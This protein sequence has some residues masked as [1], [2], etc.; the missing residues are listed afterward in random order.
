MK[1]KKGKGDRGNMVFFKQQMCLFSKHT[2]F[3]P[4][5]KVF[6]KKVNILTITPIKFSLKFMFFFQISVFSICCMFYIVV[7]YFLK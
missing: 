6:Q 7:L 3:V 5:N 4:K 2:E 1:K